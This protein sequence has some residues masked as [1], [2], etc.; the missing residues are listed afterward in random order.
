MSLLDDWEANI[1]FLK[2]I[3]NWKIIALQC[4]RFLL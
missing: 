4:C 1:L 3:F 2:F